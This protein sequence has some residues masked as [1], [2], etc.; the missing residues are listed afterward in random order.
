MPSDRSNR[1]APK[2]QHQ[3][4]GTRTPWASRRAFL[5]AASA[6]LAGGLA[7]ARA[8]AQEPAP[9]AR[10]FATG[11]DPT[12]AA[13][14]PAQ[15]APPSAISTETLAHAEQ[16]TGVPFDAARR[17]L[18]LA[19]VRANREH[20]D[21]LRRV[22]LSPDVEPAFHFHPP[23]AARLGR[24]PAAA[25]A[26]LDWP[27]ATITVGSSADD[28]AFASV[29]ELSELLRAGKITSTELTRLALDR[30]AR[31]DPTLHC[32]VTLTAD[33]ALEQAAQA[34][35][36]RRAGRD[37]GRLHGIPYGLKDLVATRGIRTTWG[38]KPFEHQVPDHD[39]T[40]VER[41]RDA[42]AVLVAKLT[43]GEL[44]IGDFW[45][46]GR[47]RNPWNP[48]RGS[49][50]SSAGPAAAVAAGLVP[51]AIGTETNGS[52]VS[53]SSACG[54]TGLRP[55]YGRVSR[56]G[57]MALRW[58]LDKVGVIARAAEDTALVL[59]AIHGP[60]G[61]DE[62]AA[63]VAFEWRPGGTLAGLRAGVVEAE[64]AG[65]DAGETD[66]GRRRRAE[67]E[68]VLRA[69]VETL[70]AAGLSLRPVALPDLP[71]RAMY[72]VC[73]AEAG[74]AFDDL[75]RSGAVDDLANQGPD[76]RANQ[77]RWAR[78]VPA[79]E[80][81]RAQRIR[82]LLVREIEALFATVDVLVTPSDSASVTMTNFTG[83]PAV[84]V[85]AGLAGGLPVG[86]MFTGRY[87]DEATLLR[88][89]W[90]YQQ[91]TAWH[92]SRPPVGG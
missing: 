90:G 92:R 33:L 87:Y 36:E 8:P 1:R 14:L 68:T 61:R 57:V 17:E 9:P 40:V 72:A 23:A 35:R 52:I 45:F 64:L 28:L 11:A 54:V 19:A 49:G 91:R 43:T 6:S 50:G 26:R 56:H 20:Y 2:P 53:P 24:P 81:I 44:A 42:G 66:D 25:R 31:F 5:T 73:N 69:A 55:T 51:F 27:P 65:R 79:V 32:I 84:T 82:T 39:A 74:A 47:T 58:T 80:Y 12:A 75:V 30:L 62:T 10:S 3:A 88:V 59:D 71:A 78:F 29:Y 63:D 21:A 86:L 13:R 77:L 48:E 85:P 34:D 7:A 15:E 18:M 4:R 76:G 38:A 22:P 16:L 37:R 83:H 67:R 89:A 70:R 60:D 41:L 46:G